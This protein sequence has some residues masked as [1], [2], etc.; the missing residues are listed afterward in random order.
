M[1]TEKMAVDLIMLK[2]AF[3]ECEVLWGGVKLNDAD[4]SI[5]MMSRVKFTATFYHVQLNS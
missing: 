3:S 2:L 4:I 1:I 5:L